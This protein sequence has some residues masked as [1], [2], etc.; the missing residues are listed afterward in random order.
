MAIYVQQTFNLKNP[1]VPQSKAA[2]DVQ[3]V[4]GNNKFSDDLEE[5]FLDQAP[6]W[7]LPPVPTTASDFSPNLTNVEQILP[8]R[9]FLNHS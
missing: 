5:L 3:S 4:L 6:D 1:P 7:L 2:A 9:P 8:N